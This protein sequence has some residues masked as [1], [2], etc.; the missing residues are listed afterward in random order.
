[1]TVHFEEPSAG[2]GAP[3]PGATPAEA[4]PVQAPAG[5]ASTVAPGPRWPRARRFLRAVLAVVAVV[6]AVVVVTLL[7]IDIGPWLRELAERQ[8]AS[9]LKRPFA[10]GSLSARLRD[11][12]FVIGD[13]AIGGLKP[14]DRPFFTAR[15]IAVSVP[16]WSILSRELV[17]E[18]IEITDWQ[19]VVETFRDGRHNFPKFTRDSPARRGPRRFVTTVRDVQAKRGAFEYQ[20]H[21]APWSVVAPN[22][23]L[24]LR[25]TDAYRGEASFDAGTIRIG[26]FEPMSGRMRT[27]FKLDGARVLYDRIDLETDGA[28]T[29]VTGETDLARWPEQV[30]AVKSRVDFPRMKQ[31]FWAKERFALAGRGDFVG[32]FR[33]FKG[34]RELKGRF[35]SLETRLND[36]RFPG[37]EGSVLWVRDRFE[38]TS[39]RAGFYGGRL[40]LDYRMAPLGD[41]SRPGVAKLDA[42][43]EGV[44]LDQFGDARALRGLQLEGRASGRNAMEW[45]LGRFGERR[46]AGE[47]RVVAAEP[48][49]V[50]QTEPA[51]R[52]AAG[53][54]ARDEAAVPVRGP[55][56]VGTFRTPIA[57]LLRYRFDPQDVH[58]EPGWIATRRTYIELSGRTAFGVRSQ[59]PFHVTSGDW[60][61][62]DRLLAGVM[63]AFGN[64]TAPIAIGGTGTFD[65]TMTGAF[66]RPRVEGRFTGEHVRAW[67][68]DW[69]AADAH[70]V[71]EHAYADVTRAIVRDGESSM[72]VEGRF[73]LGFPRRD[74]GE[75]MNARV[76]VT[77]R[78][79]ADLRHAFDLDDYPVDGTLSGEFRVNDRY[80]A[81]IGFGRLTIEA[82]RAYREPF[83]TASANLTFEG[84]GVRLDGI[85]LVKSTGRVSGAA[86]VGWDG[87]YS[88]N[89]DGRQIPLE[90]IEA[91][92]Y[93]Q[94]PVTG[95][96]EFSASG[97]G[98]F[99]DPR[100]DV[101][102][103]VTDLFVRDEG[104]GQ[105][106][107][108]MSVRGD[109]LTLPQIEAASPG[110]PCRAP[111]ASCSTTPARWISRCGSP[112][113]RST[114]TCVWWSPA[115]HPW[116]P[117]WAAA[118]FASSAP[119]VSL[120]TCAPRRRS[121][122]STCGCTTTACAT[123]GPSSC[124]WRT[125]SRP[126]SGCAW[127]ARARRWSSSAMRSRAAN[128]CA[129]AHWGMRTSACCR[130]SS[131]TS[132]RRVS[133]S[134]RRRSPGRPASP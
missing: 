71:I 13:V 17:I 84:R 10:I 30:Y 61:E 53:V 79:I 122:R 128:G 39:A 96:V 38:V 62:S 46:G 121:S 130:G 57:G 81:P 58:L 80:Q 14:G 85:D 88:F 48:V 34:G 31:I 73:S 72:T 27:R 111:A 75:E 90:R 20:D 74:G 107:G 76:R 50:R 25:R 113:P 65:G 16:W 87:T 32:T 60:Q 110:S 22:L 41:R 83:E 64:P 89:T 2:P 109:E 28:M 24:R 51:E 12:R 67:D 115:S 47:I 127:W 43:Y 26:A 125:I 49:Q 5:V 82:G 8:G 117:P 3:N 66:R 94:L 7:S 97:S 9:Y 54:S 119:S 133:P 102:G 4:T 93:P 120:P 11:G 70:V 134:C 23:E 21:G 15:R 106:S 44:D 100:Y 103:T 33:L 123:T 131:V 132:D 40:D 35:G 45:P 105:L 68:V 29:F 98:S 69:G 99:D 116:R 77:R 1:M 19:M 129:F 63:T 104:I 6:V 108:R 124:R 42:R 101:R 86:F 59:L 95:L 118:R 55:R 37:L 78:P 18:S 92:S 56:P 114:P 36:W 126:S 112:R 52:A 91:F